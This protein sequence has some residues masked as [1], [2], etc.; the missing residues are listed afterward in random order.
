MITGQPGNGKTLCAMHYIFEFLKADPKNVCVTNIVLRDGD[1]HGYMRENNLGDSWEKM[2]R[3]KSENVPAFYAEDGRE[4]LTTKTGNVEPVKIKRSLLFV[5]DEC[6]LYWNARKWSESSSA[7]LSYIS[8][9]RHLGDTIVLITQHP[10]QVDKAFRRLVDEYWL[11][12]NLSK[13]R[14]LGFRGPDGWFSRAVYFKPPSIMDRPAE[15][16]RFRLNTG[17]EKTYDTSAGK[18]FGDAVAD[19]GQK[20]RGIPFVWGMAVVGVVLIAVV[21]VVQKIPDM[22]GYGLN[23]MTGGV[24]RVATNAIKGAEAFTGDLM[25]GV[26]GKHSGQHVETNLSMGWVT[27]PQWYSGR[28]TVNGRTLKI[29]GVRDVLVWTNLPAQNIDTENRSPSFEERSAQ[30][31]QKPLNP[32]ANPYASAPTKV[33]WLRMWDGSRRPIRVRNYE[34]R[35]WDGISERNGDAD[36]ESGSEAG[37]DWSIDN[38]GAGQD[39]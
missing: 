36:N 3:L 29:Q 12:T 39:R 21:A 22:V 25:P 30:Q 1:L 14:V 33:V 28:E 38:G 23:A 17:I 37:R 5:I 6:H 11:I 19:T 9:H 16:V 20:K 32:V 7:V 26:V 34:T 8:Q 10:E 24:D 4:F 35:D 13:R 15:K 2:L 31:Q 18:G 27:V